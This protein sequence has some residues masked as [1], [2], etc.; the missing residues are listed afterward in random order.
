MTIQVTS[1][2]F[3]DGD[4]IPATYTVDGADLS[5][6]IS[7]QGIPDGTV[8]IALIC[9]DPD[10]P[11]GTWVHWVVW[12]IPPKIDGLEEALPPD[13]ELKNGIRQGTTDFGR[14]GYGGPAPPS[15]VHRYYFKMYA[16]D[17]TLN[18]RAGATKSELESA[19]KGHVLAKG[20]LMGKYSRENK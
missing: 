11:M 12:N 14:I 1:T 17:T 15:G 16:L 4:V 10:A 7:W 5:P 6:P 3:I 2:A 20:Q 13:G 9:E 8:S 18:L 19:M